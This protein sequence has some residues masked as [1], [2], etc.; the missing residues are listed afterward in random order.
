ADP[1]FQ[2]RYEAADGLCLPHLEETLT[3]A[4]DRAEA[5]LLQS[6]GRKLDPL[7]DDLDEFIRKHDYR[8]R[9]EGWQ[10]REAEAPTRAVRLAAGDLPQERRAPERRPTRRSIDKERDGSSWVP[11]E[12][13]SSPPGT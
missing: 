2:E 3:R 12:P 4:N 9:H 13:G 10:G 5:F 8:F 1:A 7:L 6:T 11:A